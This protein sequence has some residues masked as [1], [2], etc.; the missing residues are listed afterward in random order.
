[1]VYDLLYFNIILNFL[2]FQ[3][4]WNKWHKWHQFVQRIVQ[5]F[6]Q[7]FCFPPVKIC[8]YGRFTSKCRDVAIPKKRFCEKHWREERE[9]HNLYHFVRDNI[10]KN[11]LDIGILRGDLRYPNHHHHEYPE[12]VYANR[13]IL[14]GVELAMRQKY[15]DRYN[16]DV[17]NKP[18]GNGRNI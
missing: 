8:Q 5:R 16:F 3:Y 18:Y 2:T 6:L 12:N 4:K 10:Y 14:I 9:F 13:N 11:Y 15:E 7:L 1:M 17:E